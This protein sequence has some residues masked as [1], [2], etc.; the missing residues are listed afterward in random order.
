MLARWEMETLFLPLVRY[1]IHAIGANPA[2]F[3]TEV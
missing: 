3:A 1:L 2:Q